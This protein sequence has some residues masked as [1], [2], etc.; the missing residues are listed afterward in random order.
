MIPG[1]SRCVGT[2]QPPGPQW[3]YL[4]RT[5][6]DM[7]VRGIFEL[8][9]VNKSAFGTLSCNLS[10]QAKTQTARVFSSASSETRSPLQTVGKLH[11]QCRPRRDSKCALL[12]SL[13]GIHYV[14]LSV[15][16]DHCTAAEHSRSG[17]HTT[18]R[19]LLERLSTHHPRRWYK[20]C[21]AC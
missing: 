1:Q 18:N 15:R 10:F 19:G 20:N 3:S 9:Q 2:F 17:W 7:P 21:Q 11:Y 14:D 8:R 13:I 16:T 6:A 12:S 5:T 4:L